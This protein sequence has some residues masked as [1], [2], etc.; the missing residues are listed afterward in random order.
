[1]EA[2]IVAKKKAAVATKKASVVKKSASFKGG[3][4][5][6]MPSL[7]EAKRR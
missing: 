3:I 2:P 4:Y 7:P 6:T 5:W 1:M